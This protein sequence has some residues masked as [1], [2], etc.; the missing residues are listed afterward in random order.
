MK[1]LIPM[2]IC[3][4][5]DGTVS[6]GNMQEY[7]LM[8]ALK[9]ESASAFWKESNDL[10]YANEADEIAA[11]MHLILAKLKEKKIRPTRAAFQKFGSDI[12]LYAGVA[13]WFK[14][15]NA[16]ALSKGV[17]LKH[18]IISSGLKEMV[19]GMPIAKEFEAIFASTYMYNLKGEAFWPAMV[20]NYTSKTQFI[21][22]I[23]KGCEDLRDNKTIN[24]YISRNER[25]MPF[26]NMIYIGDGETDIP[27][28]KM[29]KMEGGHSIAV[30]DA[31]K[32][33]PSK[34]DRLVADNRVNAVKAADYRAGRPLEKYIHSVI[35]KVVADDTL[36]AQGVNE[37]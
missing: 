23:N 13:G 31:R 24:R 25:P 10:A 17:L 18:Y 7:G 32:E 29:V 4:D 34:I 12:K 1:K 3:Y 8:K 22:R 28:M 6:P 27:C 16:Y 33:K 14:R 19:E 26:E 11:Y 36:K 15:I 21:F 2:A 35:D 9:Q 30:Y 20:L 5:F 37:K